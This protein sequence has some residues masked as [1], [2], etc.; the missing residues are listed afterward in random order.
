MT[1]VINLNILNFFHQKRHNNNC[2]ADNVRFNTFFKD[3]QKDNPSDKNQV[4]DITPFCRVVSDECNLTVKNTT[5]TSNDLSTDRYTVNSIE[6]FSTYGRNGEKV[7]L[8]LSKGLH[9][10]SYA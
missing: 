4:I 5:L 9:I 7:Q 3:K 2:A 10:D 1:T 8:Y 6:S